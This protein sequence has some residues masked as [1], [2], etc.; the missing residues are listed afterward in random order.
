MINTQ[1]LNKN[2]E[3]KTKKVNKIK[4]PTTAYTQ[5]SFSQNS[6]KDHKNITRLFEKEYIPSFIV[7]EKDLANNETFNVNTIL[8]TIS[9]YIRIPLHSHTFLGLLHRIIVNEHN[10]PAFKP[11]DNL[12][13]KRKTFSCMVTYINFATLYA[14]TLQTNSK[15]LSFTP[16]AL[17]A[18]VYGLFTLPN[19]NLFVCDY[20]LRQPYDEATSIFLE[21]SFKMF[22]YFQ[23]QLFKNI[24]LLQTKNS[25]HIND[26]ITKTSSSTMTFHNFKRL[27]FNS[28]PI[29]LHVSTSTIPLK[30][31]ATDLDIFSFFIREDI[32]SEFLSKNRMQ[33][34]TLTHLKTLVGVACII[35]GGVFL[36][37]YVFGSAS[38]KALG[39]A[40]LPLNQGLTAAQKV[41]TNAIGDT[42]TTSALAGAAMNDVANAL[43]TQSYIGTDVFKALSTRVDSLEVN[44]EAAVKFSE[45]INFTMVQAF[46]EVKQAF[47]KTNI[48]HFRD[49]AHSLQQLLNQD[50]NS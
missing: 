9:Q 31:F 35:V 13:L 20:A 22:S 44:Q 34:K 29:T 1:N 36:I 18:D 33:L 30:F 10:L 6:T 24:A 32:S 47:W 46:E 39:N 37:A 17:L 8:N 43:E 48:P 25:L 12:K 21:K 19:E 15:N 49:A 26:L 4:K 11:E 23:G 41:T 40:Q 2:T 14:I 16:Q 45:V 28:G 3:L 38:T 27:L 5:Q 7:N 42:A 50:V